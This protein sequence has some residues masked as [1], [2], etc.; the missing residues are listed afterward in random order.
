MS[1]YT[2]GA[3]FERRVRD[4]YRKLGYF[5]IRSSGSYSPIDLAVFKGGEVKLIQC[6][7][8][9]RLDP[10]ER[11]QLQDLAR[12]TVCRV[13]LISNR[14]HKLVSEEIKEE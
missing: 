4:R 13:L 11:A 12:E 5:V 6:K 1:N 9:G 8:D 14:D 2:R 7:L 10:V 3:D